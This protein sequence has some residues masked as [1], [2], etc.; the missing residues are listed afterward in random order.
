V[1]FPFAARKLL[2]AFAAL[3]LLPFALTG[4]GSSDSSPEADWAQNFCD[5][6]GQWKSSV[7]DAGQTLANTG[8]LSK[9]KAQDAVDSISNANSKLVDDLKD[10]GKPSGS[11]GPQAKADVDDLSQELKDDADTVEN[12]MKGVSNTQELL[13]AVSTMASAASSAAT[14][15]SSTISKLKS[16]DVSQEWK[17]AFQNSEA[18]RS[19]K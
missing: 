10:L 8:D 7:T 9:S 14:S 6:L 18:C 17:Q 5:A 13:G 4:C 2:I 19:L 11:G 16:L 12:A 15:V 1:R 3:L